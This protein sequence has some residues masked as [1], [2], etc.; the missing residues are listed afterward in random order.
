MRFIKISTTDLMNRFLLAQ[1]H[2]EDLAT[3]HNVK[4]IIEALAKLSQASNPLPQRLDETYDQTMKRIEAQNLND[5]EL[6]KKVLLWI[7]NT[8]RPLS[9]EELQHALLFESDESELDLNGIHDPQLIVTVCGGL[10]AM[11]DSADGGYP[12]RIIRRCRLVHY[13]AQEY[14]ERKQA[15]YFPDAH[16]VIFKACIFQLMS[17]PSQPIAKDTG[18]MIENIIGELISLPPNCEPTLS[19]LISISKH[20]RHFEAFNYSYAIQNWA[21]HFAWTSNGSADACLF[22]FFDNTIALRYHLLLYILNHGCLRSIKTV[23][24]DI[25]KCPSHDQRYFGAIIAALFGMVRGLELEIRR[26]EININEIH[27]SGTGLLFIPIM[28]G[29]N[30]GPAVIETLL[31]FGADVNQSQEFS[32]ERSHYKSFLGESDGGITTPLIVAARLNMYQV[33]TTLLNRKGICLTATNLKGETAKEVAQKKGHSRMVGLLDDAIMRAAETQHDDIQEP[34]NTHGCTC[35]GIAKA[36]P[37]LEFTFSGTL[38]PPL[39]DSLSML[40]L[41]VF[42]SITIHSIV[43]F[44]PFFHLC[45]DF[46]ALFPKEGGSGVKEGTRD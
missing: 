22:K 39:A 29:L 26:K 36:I 46:L 17:L 1:L 28:L 7:T 10:V 18:Y 30:A 31:D 41:A 27:L 21:S 37:R 4:Q 20:N 24:D 8:F 38:F 6:A 9:V 13:T 2:L 3:K 45:M 40:H 19:M 43:A 34:H 14:F 12:Y 11:V 33:A 32:L 25:Y 16:T 44:N 23:V 5:R 15:Q 42:L 35:A